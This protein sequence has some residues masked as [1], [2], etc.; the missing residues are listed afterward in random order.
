MNSVTAKRQGVGWPLGGELATGF[1]KISL[2][3]FIAPQGGLGGGP[4]G[5]RGRA[6]SPLGGGLWRPRA[7]GANIYPPG[8]RPARSQ[9]SQE[10]G[11]PGVGPVRS[12]ASQESGFW[13]NNK[14][15]CGTRR[16]PLCEVSAHLIPI[17]I[18]IVIVIV[19]YCCYCYCYFYG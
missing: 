6:Q 15:I 1:V 10:S 18:V 11:Q 3:F 14:L 2:D 19:S 5:G 13:S 9:A 7:Q 4:L 17:V 8:V 12:Q 16:R